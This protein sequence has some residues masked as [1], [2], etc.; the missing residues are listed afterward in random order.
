MLL[1]CT[2][3]LADLMKVDLVKYDELE[4]NPLFDWT[5]TL[6][7]RGKRQG[8]LM[9]NDKTRYPIVLFGL[10]PCD[11]KDFDDLV[12]TTIRKSFS[13]NEFPI[14]AINRYMKALSV[15]TYSKTHSRSIL[16]QMT[17]IY[18]G[19]ELSD[20][21]YFETSS[22]YSFGLSEIAGCYLYKDFETKKIFTGV[23]AM[24]LELNCPIP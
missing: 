1:E 10:N 2:K 19:M 8:V 6:I 12:L 7:T 13:D 14:D 3:K 20:A 23:E 15:P 22:G 21:A 4:S 11:F 9:M 18:S 5:V 17:S 24:K 16:G